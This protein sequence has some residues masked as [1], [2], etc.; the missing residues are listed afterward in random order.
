MKRYIKKIVKD[1]D[2]LSPIYLVWRYFN[3]IKVS[4]VDMF[5]YRELSY[6]NTITLHTNEQQESDS[7]FVHIDNMKKQKKYDL[8]LPL[9]EKGARVLDLACG[10]GELQVFL[11]EYFNGDVSYTG[12][13]YTPQR[14]KSAQNLNR[15]VHLLDCSNRVELAKFI[16]ENGPFDVVFCVYAL[17]VFPTP[18]L[19]LETL[20]DKAHQV[21][22]GCFNGGHWLYRLR[23]L[24][25]RGP[26]ASAAHYGYYDKTN[27]EEVKR[28]W[29]YRDYKYLFKSLGYKYR[30]I[31]V[32]SSATSIHKKRFRFLL[33]S[34][35]GVGF[36]F[37]LEPDIKKNKENQV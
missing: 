26:C 34:L 28:W 3:N 37:L 23:F 18:E 24:F 21:V 6:E 25:G 15:N 32:K 33:P 8:V 2:A 1:N 14:V 9:I 31:S 7:E 11:Q 4:F 27:F 20:R 22:V 10:R 19:I 30:L 12:L 17:T 36:M 13:D 35:S 29:T 16:D 5:I